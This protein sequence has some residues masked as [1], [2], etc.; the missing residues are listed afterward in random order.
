MCFKY[1]LLTGLSQE[2]IGKNLQRIP[3]IRPSINQYEW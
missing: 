2:K 3:K 1:V